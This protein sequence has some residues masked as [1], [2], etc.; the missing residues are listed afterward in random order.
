[1]EQR[2]YGYVNGKAVYSRDEFTFAARGFGPIENDDELLAFA[3]KVTSNWYDA[4]WHRT[5]TH[6]YLSDYALSE[7][8][9]S[10]TLKEFARLKDLQK[11]AIAAEKLQMTPASGIQGDDL[12]GRQ[13]RRGGLGGQGRK[14]QDGDGD[15][16]ARGR[17]LNKSSAE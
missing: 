13:Q 1:M 8:Y 6:F 11:E 7:P 16:S 10:L 2:V 12:L 15:R 17:M 9:R 14:H 3:Q 4:G 5:F